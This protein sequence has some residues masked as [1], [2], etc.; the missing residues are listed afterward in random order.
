MVLA[1]ALCESGEDSLECERLSNKLATLCRRVHG[2]DHHFAENIELVLE[3]CRIRKVT[4]AAD[5]GVK[6]YQALQFIKEEGKYIINGPISNPRVSDEENIIKVGVNAAGDTC[7]M[8]RAEKIG[9]VTSFDNKAGRYVVRF[10]DKS[11]KPALIKPEN[12]QI[13]IDL[14][15]E[16]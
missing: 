1:Q 13:V 11:V 4:M 7:Y 8:P 6:E 12:L 14:P 3:L 15:D 10:E 9:D 16:H 5:D 2:P